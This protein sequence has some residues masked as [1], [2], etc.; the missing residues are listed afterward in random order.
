MRVFRIGLKGE[1]YKVSMP[2]A[3]R[4]ENNWKFKS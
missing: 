4:Y 3:E 2:S 1:K